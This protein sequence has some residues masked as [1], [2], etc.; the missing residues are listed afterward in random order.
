[1][2]VG[3]PIGSGWNLMP[4]DV[5]QVA[6]LAPL[7]W[8]VGPV[9][10]YNVYAI[11]SYPLTA[12]FTL[13]LCRRL[14]I[15]GSGAAFAAL[16]YAFMPLHTE[17]AQAHLMQSHMEFFPAFLWLTVRWRLGGSGWNLVGAGCAAG[18]TLWNDTYMAAILV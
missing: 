17:K 11:L 7:S 13:L 2:L 3:V 15:S 14:G 8:L 12:L 16:A 18:L 10:A 1:T 9:A 4:F 6:V 5:L